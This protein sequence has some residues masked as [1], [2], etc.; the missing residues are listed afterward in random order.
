MLVVAGL[1]HVEEGRIASLCGLNSCC[2]AVP[3][4]FKLHAS[5][6]FWRQEISSKNPVLTVLQFLKIAVRRRTQCCAF[7]FVWRRK[8][9]EHNHD[10]YNDHYLHNFSPA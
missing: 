6:P 5:L 3:F 4:E 7:V 10:H 2:V 1:F 9:N 8:T